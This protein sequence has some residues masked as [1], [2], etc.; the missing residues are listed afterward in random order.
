MG[1]QPQKRRSRT[2]RTP[3]FDTAPQ[4]RDIAVFHE[5]WEARVATSEQL[6]LRFFPSKGASDRRLRK[7]YDGRYIQRRAKLVEQGRGELWYMLDRRG[8]EVLQQQGYEYVKFHSSYAKMKAHHILHCIAVEWF[9]IYLFEACQHFGFELEWIPEI[10]FRVP[11]GYD[12]VTLDGQ[13]I[14]VIPDA[15]FYIRRG[16]KT[17]FF[18]LELDRGTAKLSRYR[19]K[20][21]C[22][23]FYMRSQA[24]LD[25]FGMTRENMSLR[26]L[27]V[28]DT[29]G[30][31]DQAGSRRLKYLMQQ[32]DDPKVKGLKPARRFWF[33][34]LLNLEAVNILSR[35]V[36]NVR[37]GEELDVLL[38][39]FDPKRS[40]D[41]P[42]LAD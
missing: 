25:H 33:T 17:S 10:R 16:E 1:K 19:D 24:F 7:L 6:A 39:E 4:K 13:E 35:P 9:K 11:G 27:T 29:E 32:M 42:S 15:A 18:C 8:Y 41:N 5:L 28:V 37:P 12:K 20:V 2:E 26:V 23:L 36:W 38:E 40:Y 30:L 22:Y 31:T 14:G 34:R 3:G 21:R